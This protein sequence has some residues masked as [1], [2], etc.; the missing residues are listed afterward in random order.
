MKKALPEQPART[1]RKPAPASSRLRSLLLWWQPLPRRPYWLWIFMAG[2][3][4]F[5]VACFYWMRPFAVPQSRV[6]A[7]RPLVV[8]LDPASP[9]SA[10]LAE[11]SSLL[12][13]EPLFLPTG[14]NAEPERASVFDRSRRSEPFKAY[15]AEISTE[16]ATVPVMATPLLPQ[17]PQEA[18]ELDSSAIFTTFGRTAAE[19]LALA[20]RQGQVQVES[21]HAVRPP[22]FVD[23]PSQTIEGL[24]DGALGLGVFLIEVDGTGSVTLPLL[25]RSTGTDAADRLWRDYLHS[26]AT[27]WN[28]G[29][30][31]Y[32]LTVGP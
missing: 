23:I 4:L 2:A 28:L 27:G 7:G 30:G 10:T 1:G 5:H 14:W 25:R 19:T 9:Q 29:P 21:L 26:N 16:L 11:Q 18:I 3:V 13:F 32:L 24:A 31:S 22:K 17:T 8:Y 20:G 6:E 12:D 15:E